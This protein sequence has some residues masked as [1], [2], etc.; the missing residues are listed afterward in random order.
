[1]AHD[2]SGT[3]DGWGAVSPR[4]VDRFVAALAAVACALQVGGVLTIRAGASTPTPLVWLALGT[5]AGCSV[6]LAVQAVRAGSVRQPGWLLTAVGVILAASPLVGE[7][8]PSGAQ[9]WQVQ[10]W[11]VAG[12]AAVLSLPLVLAVSLA[13]VMMVGFAALQA[14]HLGWVVASLEATVV[15]LLSLFAGLLV[16]LSR[17]AARSLERATSARAEATAAEARARAGAQSRAWW[18]QD[19]HA[20]V[21]P[22]LD[23]GAAVSAADLDRVRAAARSALE[24]HHPPQDTD[25]LVAHT[26]RYAAQL[27]LDLEV[28]VETLGDPP[29]EIA[30]AL[31]GALSEALANVARHSGVQRAILSGRVAP[32]AVTLSV[33]DAG[34]GFD[35]AAIHRLGYGIRTGVRQRMD[36]VAGAVD[37]RSGRGAGTTVTLTW[38]GEEPRRDL[39]V[40]R[41]PFTWLLVPGVLSLAIHIG[42]GWLLTAETTHHPWAVP[43][44]GATLAV[45][46]A[47]AVLSARLPW[48]GPVVSLLTPLTVGLLLANAVPTDAADY[49]TWMT[50]ASVPV[51]VTLAVVGRHRCG[52]VGAVLTLLAVLGVGGAAGWHLGLLLA[53]STQVVLVPVWAVLTFAF[54]E[55]YA[56]RGV[57]AVEE[58]AAAHTRSV[59]LQAR[60]DRWHADAARVE[61]VVGPTLRCLSEAE[62]ATA[63]LRAECLRARATL[64]RE[65]TALSKAA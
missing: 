50:G 7:Q 55:R 58:A 56:A 42:L 59:E 8:N 41:W 35:A 32:L 57:R 13:V 22:V 27:G 33:T 37:I 26:R 20:R 24:H 43:A 3:A 52:V 34:Q 19:V 14:P 62:Q 15:L 54:S 48:L 25:T 45:L 28:E 2:S 30:A 47:T 49:R 10:Y 21:L 63:E 44:G 64:H 53:V 5:L 40:P 60:A 11:M 46:L 9:P 16:L 4:T 51:L 18:V 12:F 23:A 38:A 36:T 39:L 1:M 29:P 65:L 31:T 6:W 17:V 61:A